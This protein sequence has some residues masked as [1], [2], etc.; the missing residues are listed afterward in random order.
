MK[1]QEKLVQ[2][3]SDALMINS[4]IV[5]NDLEYLSIPEWDSISHMVLISELEAQFSISLQTDD[6]ID[7]SSFAK[8]IEIL[9]KHG[10][11]FSL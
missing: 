11:D 7:M 2:A 5:N 8:A 4:E 9:E 10:V 1:N 6:V 3:F